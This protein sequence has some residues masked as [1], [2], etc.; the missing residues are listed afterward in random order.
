MAQADGAGAFVGGMVTA[1]AINNMERRTEAEED[2]YD[3]QRSSGS[4][5]SSGGGGG[6]STEERLEKLDDLARGGYISKEEYQRRRQ[7]ILN[8]I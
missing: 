8:Q 7:A 4:S 2:Y 1:R 3:D 6:G 5:Q